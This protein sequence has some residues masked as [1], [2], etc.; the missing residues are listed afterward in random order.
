[1]AA[2]ETAAVIVLVLDRSAPLTRTTMRCWQRRLAAA[3][4]RREQGRSAPGVGTASIGTP[5]LKLSARTGPGFQDLRGALVEATMREPSRD[6]P[7]LTNLRHADLL[8]RAPRPSSRAERG[9]IRHSR[10]IRALRPARGAQPLEEVTGA[11]TP[12]DVLNAIFARF[13]IGK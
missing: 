3:R 10:G 4:R 7:P 8:R 13:C 5:V 6:A 12:D 2:R 11:R 9:G 1:M